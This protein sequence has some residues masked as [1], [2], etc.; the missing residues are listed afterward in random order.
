MGGIYIAGELGGSSDISSYNVTFFGLGNA[1]SL[2]FSSFLSTRFGAAKTL[3]FAMIAFFFTLFFSGLMETFFLFVTFHFLSGVA[4]GLFF[5]LSQELL[6]THLPPKKQDLSFAFLALLTTLT[7]VLGACFGGW[8]AYDFTWEAIFYLQIPVL[9]LTYCLISLNKEKPLLEKPPFDL[10]GAIFYL[11]SILTLTTAICLGQQLDWF[12]SPTINALLVSGVL[13]LLFFILWEWRHEN[14]FWD[15]K[16][17]KIPAVTLSIIL[18]TFLFSAYFGMVILLSL[19]LHLDA[20]YTPLWISLILLNMVFAG[21]FLFIF[22]IKWMKKTHPFFPVFFAIGF[23][24]ISCFYSSTFNA[25][26]N[27]GKIA[28]A[29][30]FA[31]LGLAFFVFPL[32]SICLNNLPATKKTQGSCMFQSLRLLSGGLGVSVYTTIWYRRKIF[33]H[34]R[35]GSSLTVYSENTKEFFSQIAF[36]GP[37]GLAADELLEEALLKQA[38][39][40]ALADCFYLMAI[41]MTILLA[42]LTAYVFLPKVIELYKQKNPLKN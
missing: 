36:F 19:W 32:L 9:I 8:I 7:P 41:I 1:C 13:C 12:R 37:K 6:N 23:F 34:E 35:L 33:Y 26:T 29:R 20:N 30:I 38:T 17:L 4:C 21:I 14:P 3:K 11:L 28:L 5:P 27:F 25:E 42:F 15:L 22:M 24:A 39:A 18:I 31:G 40:L 16:L 2:P 10:V